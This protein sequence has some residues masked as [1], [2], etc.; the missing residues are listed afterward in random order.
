MSPFPPPLLS[1]VSA[2]P[3]A[4]SHKSTLTKNQKKKK[5]KKI[6]KALQ[7][8]SEQDGGREKVTEASEDKAKEEGLTDKLTER[9][10]DNPDRQ[11][12]LL[13]KENSLDI[14]TIKGWQKKKKID[15]WVPLCQR[16]I[17]CYTRK[18]CGCWRC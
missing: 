5:K 14:E 12:E 2:A 18:W 15:S 4:N 11:K 17:F 6:K 13:D 3:V 9:A 1:A 10:R 8:S 7:M 16:E